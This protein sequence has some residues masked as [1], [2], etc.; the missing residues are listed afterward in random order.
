VRNEKNPKERLDVIRWRND[1]SGEKSR[2]GG[3]KNE[4]TE[5]RMKPES[6]VWRGQIRAGMRK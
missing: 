1:G 6:T 4:W 5:D 2:D 3:R